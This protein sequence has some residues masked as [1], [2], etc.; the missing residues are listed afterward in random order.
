MLRSTYPSSLFRLPLILS[1]HSCTLP[2]VNFSTAVGL[3]HGSPLI[4]ISALTLRLRAALE[5][6]VSVSL[7]VSMSVS[8]S[9]SVSVSVSVGLSV[10][11]SL[12]VSVSVIM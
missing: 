7:S 9:V 11:A 4:P 1:R 5:C 2:W 12:S 6:P 8:L 10:S 3:H